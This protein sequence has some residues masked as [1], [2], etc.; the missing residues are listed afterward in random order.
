MGPVPDHGRRH[1]DRRQ[2][3][4]HRHRKRPILYRFGRSGGHQRTKGRT[5]EGDRIPEGIPRIRREETGQREVR[6]E[7][8]ARSGGQRAEEEGRCG[9]EDQ[10]PD[11]ELA[12]IAMIMR[13][14]HGM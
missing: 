12:G 4:H 1:P 3:L 5:A 10:D 9:T 8:Q 14:D 13:D 6:R 7:R 2:G 11:P